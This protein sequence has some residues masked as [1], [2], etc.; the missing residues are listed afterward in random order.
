LRKKLALAAVAVAAA[1][2]FAPLTP[3]AAYCAF[4]LSPVGGSSCYNP[5]YTTLAA[6]DRADAAT[7]GLLPD[8]A[9][10]CLA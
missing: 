7:K 10:D 2:S 9:L 6:Y 1:A 8:H 4:D 3:A 5:C